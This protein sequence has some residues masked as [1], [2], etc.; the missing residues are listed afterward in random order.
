LG[1][2]RNLKK[3]HPKKAITQL[4]ENWPELVTLSAI[5]NFTTGPQG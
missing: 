3:K 2:F 5:L 4:P 1:Y